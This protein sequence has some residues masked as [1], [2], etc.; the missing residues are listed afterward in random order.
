M[1]HYI[2]FNIIA[3]GEAIRKITTKLYEFNNIENKTMK[4][5]I[6]I[7]KKKIVL[8]VIVTFVINSA[9]SQTKFG[10]KAGV[11]FASLSDVEGSHVR[12]LKKD[13]MAIG[14]HAGVF[15]NVSLIDVISFQPELIFSMQGGYQKDYQHETI[16]PK[17]LHVPESF[18]SY[19]FQLGYIQLP[20]LFEIKPVANLGILTGVQLGLNISRKCINIK[21]RGRGTDY[22][23]FY[24]SGFKKLDAGLVYGLQYTFADKIT[25][26]ARYNLGLSN[27]LDHNSYHIRQKINAKGWK[28]NVIQAGLGFLF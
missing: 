15:T 22:F 20:L 8:I 3:R 28:S 25:I 13:G 1:T 7:F 26:G 12:L 16:D 2:G 11:N 5:F 17:L 18:S 9:F 21:Y 10:I 19:L 14:F 6:I 23:N 27:N 4:S 24:G